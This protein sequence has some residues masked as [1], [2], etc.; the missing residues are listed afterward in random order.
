MSCYI[1]NLTTE[2]VALMVMPC[3]GAQVHTKCGLQATWS[4]FNNI[5]CWSCNTLLLGNMPYTQDTIPPAFFEEAVP[6]K[7]KVAAYK[8][9]KRPLAAVIKAE[10]TN[11]KLVTAPHIQAIKDYKKAAIV[12]IKESSEYKE[13]NK[14]SRGVTNTLNGL[15]IKYNMSRRFVWNYFKLRWF[16][17]TPMTDIKR[18]FRIRI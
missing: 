7:K 15:K 5:S 10:N 18:K 16:M 11:F 9:T 14:A 2:G 17:R 6:V 13:S 4:S 8:K 3:C 1:C 12:T